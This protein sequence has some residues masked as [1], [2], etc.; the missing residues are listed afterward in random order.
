MDRREFVKLAAGGA[1]A[2]LTLN[3]DLFAYPD[4]KK[5]DRILLLIELRGGND[6]L[7]T[8]VPYT[9]KLYYKYR[10]K[11]A[12]PPPQVL[13]INDTLGVNPMLKPLTEAWMKKEMAMVLGVGYPKPNRSHFR[14]ID[15][16]ETASASNEYLQEGWLAKV[17]N[18]YPISEKMA[19]HS[20]LLD[21]GKEGSLNGKDMRNIVMRNPR[22]FIRQAS[23]LKEIPVKNTGNPALDHLSGTHNNL[24]KVGKMLEKKLA[25]AKKLNVKFP[26][27]H[28]ARQLRLAANILSATIPAP[29]IKVSMGGF[30]TH[31]GQKNNHMRLMRD[32][33]QAI[34]AFRKAMME[35]GLWDRM[36]VMTYSEFGRRVKENGSAGTDHGTAAPH[37]FFGGK[38]KG[39]VYGKQ[40]LLSDLNRGDLKFTTD[41]RSMYL[42]VIEKWLGIKENFWSKDKISSIDC[43]S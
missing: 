1:L 3:P 11:I 6:G 43:I 5:L 2:F 28:L 9:D 38:V 36:L 27:S 4:E 15:I 25:Q 26:G 7:N 8:V 41:F 17:F 24:V 14:S 13:K 16:W 20:F 30:D 10:P 21:R 18:K 32:F 33:G 39:G 22:H 37:F 42:T 40:P 19:A 31:T 12:I 29:V 35:I 23:K 34:A